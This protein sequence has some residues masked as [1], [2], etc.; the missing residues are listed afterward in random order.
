MQDE[1]FVDVLTKILVER[2]VI[3]ATEAAALRRTFHEAAKPNFDEFLL[4]EGLV[5]KDDLLPALAQMYQVPAFDAVG[6]LFDHQLVRMFPKE[7]L[8]Q[9]AIIPIER[10]ENMLFF[11]A[12]NPADE[13][14]LPAIGE[15]VSYDVRFKVGIRQDIVNA[16]QE[17][18]DQSVA[19]VNPEI[20]KDFDETRQEREGEIRKDESLEE[21]YSEDIKDIEEDKS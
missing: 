17:F 20:D 1:T 4:D 21:I 15:H 5:N 18:Y 3:K 10:D 12:S 13:E 7:F 11:V 2:D 16:V 6:Y 14:L 8:M 9:H 19:E